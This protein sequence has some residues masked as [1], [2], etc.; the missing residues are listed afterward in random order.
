MRA[1]DSSP[2]SSESIR[3][4]G[5]ECVLAKVSISCCT[6][7]SRTRS[8]YSTIA[9]VIHTRGEG[10]HC[11]ARTMSTRL[12]AAMKIQGKDPGRCAGFVA[13]RERAENT[14][15]GWNV[16]IASSMKDSV[17]GSCASML[18]P[19]VYAPQAAS[20]RRRA[21]DK[22]SS[23]PKPWKAEGPRPS[24]TGRDCAFTCPNVAFATHAFRAAKILGWVDLDQSRI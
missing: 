14:V 13:W 9:F 4:R 18:A 22:N 6:A 11:N 7:A 8:T 15:F 19:D 12:P 1:R 2:P 23:R 3:S 24:R 10:R 5:L 21:R 16:S 20:T 17:Q